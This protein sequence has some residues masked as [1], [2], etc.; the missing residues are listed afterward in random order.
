MD[1]FQ[2][3]VYFLNEDLKIDDKAV[4]D[5]TDE[6][7]YMRK[8]V[9]IDFGDEFDSLMTAITEV[10][11]TWLQDYGKE[12]IEHDVHERIFKTMMVE[13]AN[14]LGSLSY[15]IGNVLEVMDG[16]LTTDKEYLTAL[17]SYTGRVQSLLE[18]IAKQ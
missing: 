10:V 18:K 9:S 17:N 13:K 16:N 12:H 8:Q 1:E 6:V 15:H 5:M 7:Y 4:K 11:V 3:R 14:E 2:R